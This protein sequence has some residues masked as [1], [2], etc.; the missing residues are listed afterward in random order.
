MID[1]HYPYS[2][3][4]FIHFFSAIFL[5]SFFISAASFHRLPHFLK[6]I[7][8]YFLC[9]FKSNEKLGSMW[10]NMAG[11]SSSQSTGI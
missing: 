2:Y 3:F 7:P 4:N 8:P 1:K 9:S 5:L 6:D 10:H 11:S